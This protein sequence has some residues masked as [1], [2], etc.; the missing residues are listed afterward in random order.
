MNIAGLLEHDGVRAGIHGLDVKVSELRNLRQLL[1]LRLVRP[2]VGDAVAIRD[3]VNRVVH[4]NRIHVLRIGPRRRDQIVR[5]EIDDPNGAI[6]TAAIVAALFVPRIVHAISDVCSVGGDFALI[7]ARQ[8]HRLFHSAFRR[9]SPEARRAAGR[10]PRAGRG[11]EN[12]SAVGSPT[13]HRVRAGMPGQ[14]LRLAALSGDHINIEVA[15]VLAAKGNPF[16]IGREMRIRRLALEARDAPRHA[17]RA[18]RHPNILR[19]G[20]CDLRGAH[21]WRAQQTRV[22]SLSRSEAAGKENGAEDQSA[23]AK[24]RRKQARGHQFSSR[25]TDSGFA[26][27]F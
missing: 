11:K 3:E 27:F 25:R 7:R 19:I 17:T 14:T 4:P 12:R 15:G 21:R 1:C 16:S 22:G 23:A 2:N 18:R 24:L 10:P 5:F 6:L 9:N 26:R 20:K 13:L 8:R